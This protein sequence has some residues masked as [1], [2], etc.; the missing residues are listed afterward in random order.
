MEWDGGDYPG[1]GIRAATTATRRT[2]T[3]VHEL[4][5]ALG[6]DHNGLNHCVS[7]MADLRSDYPDPCRLPGTHDVEDVR[8]YWR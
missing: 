4:G 5:H 8:D 3:V 1:L 6:L 2:R 7:I